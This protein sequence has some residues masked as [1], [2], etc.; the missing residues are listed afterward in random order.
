M[1][2]DDYMKVL[3]E[4][5]DW[6]SDYRRVALDQ[7]AIAKYVSAIRHESERKTGRL[8]DLTKIDIIKT[9]N[10]NLTHLLGHSPDYPKM[11]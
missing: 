4:L 1:T 9:V 6:L 7:R 10:N 5:A 8:S 2:F 3:K 11:C